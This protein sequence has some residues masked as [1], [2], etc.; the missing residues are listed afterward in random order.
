[1]AHKIIA[2]PPIAVCF[3]LG[4]CWARLICVPFPVL[5]SVTALLFLACFFLRDDSPS[6]DVNFLVLVVFLGAVHFSAY[7]ALSPQHLI[8]H[9]RIFSSD[10]F[11]LEGVI[12]SPLRANDNNVKFDLRALSL[13]R[14]DDISSSG[15]VF[16]SVSGRVLAVMHSFA[17]DD[18]REGMPD[19]G[20]RIILRG[21][22][23]RPRVFSDFDYREYLRRRGIYA[24]FKVDPNARIDVVA[25]N[26]GNII[27]RFAAGAVKT[28]KRKMKTMLGPVYVSVLSAMLLGDRMGLPREISSVFRRT[29]TAHILAISGMHIAILV[30]VLLSVSKSARIPRSARYTL[31]IIFLLFYGVLS[32]GR[33]SVVRAVTMA[34]ILLS[35]GLLRREAD[36]Y[37][38]LAVAALVILSY[39][40]FQIWD[41]GFQLSFVSVLSIVYLAPKL[42]RFL[43]GNNILS[44]SLRV[45]LAAW[46]ATFLLIWHYFGII[47]P[48]A[49]FANLIVVPLMSL[50]VV[51]GVIFLSALFLF[52]PAAPIFSSAVVAAITLL[53]NAARLLSYVPGAYFIL[54]PP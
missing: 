11:Y 28:V 4:I 40:P 41:V 42:K 31:T 21:R 33:P 10:S 43:P 51:S 7:T 1:M 2:A 53:V 6:F 20:D 8:N 54:S 3:S 14:G 47:S 45:S 37:S 12:I 23:Y 9:A 30:F 44:V 22:F 17:G 24:L 46:L 5:F 48:I 19:Y 38:S 34:V 15:G 32:G 13:A 26:R 36:V 39:N 52:P 25:R 49:I 27:R 50:V 29:G 18:I 16:D 35:G